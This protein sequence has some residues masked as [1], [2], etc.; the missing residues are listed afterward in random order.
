[1]TDKLA[2]ETDMPWRD[3]LL[4]L[5]TIVFALFFAVTL[6]VLLHEW[7]AWLEGVL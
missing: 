5:A 1:M 3:L 2:Q 4:W 7:K 6:V